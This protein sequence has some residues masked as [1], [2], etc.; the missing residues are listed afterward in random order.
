MIW[1]IRWCTFIIFKMCAKLKRF[2]LDEIWQKE[3]LSLHVC[4]PISWDE[5]AGKVIAI[6]TISLQY[7]PKF[8]LI[9]AFFMFH[10]KVKILCSEQYYTLLNQP[11]KLYIKTLSSIFANFAIMCWILLYKL[12]LDLTPYK[13]NAILFYIYPSISLYMHCRFDY[14]SIKDLISKRDRWNCSTIKMEKTLFLLFTIIS[15]IQGKCARLF[16]IN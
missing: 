1:N 12:H 3:N 10:L 13:K 4:I 2:W 14:S 11:S 5:I 6:D 9:L 8:F 7:T 16:L 15:F